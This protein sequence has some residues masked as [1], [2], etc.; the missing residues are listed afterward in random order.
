MPE[1]PPAETGPLI[2]ELVELARR[3]PDRIAERLS[4][5][6]LRDQAEISLLLPPRERLELL[7]HAP[8]PMRL[9]RMLPDAELHL[10]AREIGPTE[11][12]PLISLASSSQLIHLMDLESWRHDE[13]DAKRSGA[14]VALLLEAGEPTLKRF[15][16]K[17][18]DEL[19][20]LLLKNWA[21]ISQ[22]EDEDGPD[23]H[24]TGETEA[25]TELGFVSPDGYHRFS[26]VIPEHGPAVRRLSE[27]LTHE[28][29]ER[30][31]AIVWSAIQETRS[32]LEEQAL[33]WRQSRFEEHGFPTRDE[34]L[35]I[36][37]PPAG[38]RGHGEPPPPE[39][40]EA[41]A[42]PRAPLRLLDS[43]NL[44]V[45]ATERLGGADR[46]RVLFETTALANRILVA[47]SAD[48]GDPEDH[49]RALFKAASY[50][51]V[52][53]AARGAG[54]VPG[55]ARVLR[56]VSVIELFREGFEKALQLQS[57]ARRLLE[58]GWAAVHPKALELLDPPI[59]PSFMGLLQRRPLYFDS[60]AGGE[61]VVFRDFRSME[62]I[63]EVRA[64][65]QMAEVLGRVMVERLG[66]DIAAVLEEEDSHPMGPPRFSVL[67][68][69][70]L[71]WNATR[72][73][74][75]CEPL[76]QAL[77]SQFLRTVASARTA[78]PEAPARALE[79]LIRRLATE[80]EL[81]PADIAVLRAFGRACL[82]KL[83]EECSALD[84]GAPVDPRYVSC[85]LIA[86]A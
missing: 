33:H 21:C 35:S 83:R 81:G 80:T 42:A 52:A 10:T 57:R 71:A 19:L 4:S 30:Y 76:S 45:A 61:E 31:Q 36:Y 85:L 32:G 1:D 7:L 37:A 24:G 16:K 74:L 59:R 56:E 41:L 58:Q 70:V 38:V 23:K 79:A 47:D 77:T 48:T 67:F 20:A 82:E 66:L 6:P 14:W 18:D 78:D 68:L 39:F 55:A 62:E 26:P 8:R 40:P 49:R 11:A 46:E 27:I 50:L 63:E 51:S 34:A 65:L 84:P 75:R 53:M 54:D 12:L 15:L 9:V 25:G 28:W 60:T 22:I 17:A 86:D 13:F 72:G 64:A 3:A 2:R 5:M 44:L 29:P 69:T 43:K 73:D